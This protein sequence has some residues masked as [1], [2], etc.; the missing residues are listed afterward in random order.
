[1]IIDDFGPWRCFSSINDSSDGAEARVFHY[2]V[3]FDTKPSHFAMSENIRSKNWIFSMKRMRAFFGRQKG[4][5]ATQTTNNT[6]SSTGKSNNGY[7]NI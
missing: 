6:A 7:L 3:L 4:L 1:M 2:A 5:L